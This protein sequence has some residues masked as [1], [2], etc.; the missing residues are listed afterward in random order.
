MSMCMYVSWLKSNIKSWLKIL[1]QWFSLSACLWTWLISLINLSI[2]DPL[3]TARDPSVETFTIK[4]SFGPDPPVVHW[5]PF[6][7]WTA[8]PHACAELKSQSHSPFWKEFLQEAIANKNQHNKAAFGGIDAK[9]P[10][11]SLWDEKR[12][13]QDKFD[14]SCPGVNEPVWDW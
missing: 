14:E 13:F 9:E 8:L 1:F 12:D 6:P 10:A 3:T 5:S 2:A 4:G 11:F 7:H